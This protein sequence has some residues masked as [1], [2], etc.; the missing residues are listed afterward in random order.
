MTS[1]RDALVGPPSVPRHHVPHRLDPERVLVQDVEVVPVEV[2]VVGQLPVRSDQMAFFEKFHVGQA[3]RI[4]HHV[5]TPEPAVKVKVKARGENGKDHTAAF[6]AGEFGQPAGVEINLAELFPTRN[7]D[8]G[9]SIVVA[10]GVVGT[11]EPARRSAAVLDDLSAAMTAGV[12]E[13]F[14]RAVGLAHREH[15][16]AGDVN[17]PI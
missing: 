12:D 10:P 14:D 4:E 8:E 6:F 9:T 11:R 13:R 16:Y 15:R 1:E 17:R 2:S 5:V 3:E 7:A